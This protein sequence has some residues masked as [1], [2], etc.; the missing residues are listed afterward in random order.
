MLP[1]KI[2]V[3]P[4]KFKGTLTATQAA[5]AIERGLRARVPGGG[6]LAV[7]LLPIADGGEGTTDAICAALPGARLVAVPS[8]GPFGEPREGEAAVS[9]SDAFFEM[10]CV[11]GLKLVTSQSRDPWR[12]TTRGVGEMLRAL[13]V[14]GAK[15]IHVGLGGS[16]TNDAGLGVG[17]ALDYRFLDAR[18]N[19]VVPLPE[20]YERITGIVAP[21]KNPLE[22]VEVTG[23]CDVTNPLLGSDGAS[24]VY[25][26]QK[27][28]RD[29]ARLDAVLARIAGLVARDMGVDYRDTPGAGAAGG[30]GYGLMTFAG[31]KLKP[32]FETIAA[33]A[34]IEAAVRECDL[35]ITGEGRL[36]N[37][38]LFGKGPAE[39]A[40]LAR[41][42]GK[43]VV[44]FGGCVEAGAEKGLREVFADIYTLTGA[45]SAGAGAGAA[46]EAA[47]SRFAA[48]RMQ[49]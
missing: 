45:D 23:L 17:A 21:A 12:A 47:A 48:E 46:L 40:R 31:A 2:L 22:G 11:S 49:S 16:A 29:P 28:L 24:H 1:Q 36:D 7:R 9:G 41:R 33:L 5:R 38:T 20:N 6:A 30:L 27:G 32:G 10:A 18:G 34:G 4:D 44:A 25:G 8:A 39:L 37:Q 3:A 35:V 13:A 42:E 43:P 14:G 19:E 26:P 15:K